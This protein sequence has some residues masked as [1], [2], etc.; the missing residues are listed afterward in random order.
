MTPRSRPEYFTLFV[1]LDTLCI[2]I[3]VAAS[4]PDDILENLET[5]IPMV[6]VLCAGT[7][8]LAFDSYDPK[9]NASDEEQNGNDGERNVGDRGQSS[10]DEE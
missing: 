4:A 2:A 1:V 7:P 5:Y 8:S 9:H 6:T 10:R 3:L